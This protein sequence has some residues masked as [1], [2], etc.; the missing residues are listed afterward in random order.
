MRPDVKAQPSAAPP[1]VTYGF[2]SE[3]KTPIL[4]FP[5]AYKPLI[6]LPSSF[7]TLKFVSMSNAPQVLKHA[8]RPS[9]A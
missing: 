8:E 5:T 1:Y 9:T 6:G 4:S 3:Y 7:K 2:L